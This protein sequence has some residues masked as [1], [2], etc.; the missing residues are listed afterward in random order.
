MTQSKLKLIQGGLKNLKRLQNYS[1]WM[2]KSQKYTKMA[3]KWPPL[4]PKWLQN[5][6]QVPQI[7][8]K[9]ASK[10]VKIDQLGLK[11]SQDP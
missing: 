11:R 9:M 10:L 2:Q 1:K 4:A 6:P 3:P 7:E 8:S 5:G